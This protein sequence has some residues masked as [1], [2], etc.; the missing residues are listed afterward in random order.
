MVLRKQFGWRV[1]VLLVAAG[2]LCGTFLPVLIPGRQQALA[3]QA[4]KP[5]AKPPENQTYIG[6]KACAACHLDQYLTWRDTK[7]AKSFEIVPEKYRAD[8]SCLKCHTT[9]HGTDTGFKNLEATPALVGTSCEACHGPGSKHGEIAKTYA[10]KKLDKDEEG[11]VR[12]TIYKM[13]PKNVC[14][15]CHITR[16]HKKHPDYEKAK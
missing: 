14:V 3:A 15:D 16:A 7:H 4:P 2:A 11:Y 5:L 13:Q 9:G 1:G 12:S 10:N 6:T 8:A